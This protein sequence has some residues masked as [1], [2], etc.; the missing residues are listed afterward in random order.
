MVA[1]SESVMKNQ[2]KRPLAEKSRIHHIRF[3]IKPR[4]LGNHATQ[5]KVTVERY[6]EIMVAL[7]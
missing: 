3:A 1:L 2:L 6:Q 5:K 7:S 4:Y